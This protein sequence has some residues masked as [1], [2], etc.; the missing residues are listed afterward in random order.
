M[1]P[2][3]GS[4]CISLDEMAK[5]VRDAFDSERPIGQVAQGVNSL[6]QLP[7]FGEHKLVFSMT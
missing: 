6:A 3:H 5:E 4:V 1:K 7:Q 2:K